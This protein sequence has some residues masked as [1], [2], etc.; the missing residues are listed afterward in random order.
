MSKD[1][2]VNEEEFR[3]ETP[4]GKLKV[5]QSFSVQAENRRLSLLYLED[6]TTVIDVRRFEESETAPY[7]D[8]ITI[9]TMRLSK[10]TI[11]MLMACLTKANDDFAIDADKLIEDL[12]KKTENERNS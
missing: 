11:A 4:D 1:E 9:Q 6:E 5:L 10:L 12:V 2:S 7:E 3:L 8:N